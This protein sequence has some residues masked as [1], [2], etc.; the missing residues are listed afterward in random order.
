VHLAYD[1]RVP[2]AFCSICSWLPWYVCDPRGTLLGRSTGPCEC[3][4]NKSHSS[5]SL[6]RWCSACTRRQNWEFTHEVRVP[7]FSSFLLLLRVSSKLHFGLRDG[8]RQ[9]G[10]LQPIR[11]TNTVT[12]IE[13]LQR[14]LWLSNLFL[15]MFLHLDIS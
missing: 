6:S 8:L 5:L 10:F 11:V 1:G 9:K 7:S 3:S 15:P 4:L 13:G 12:A 14:K 2:Q